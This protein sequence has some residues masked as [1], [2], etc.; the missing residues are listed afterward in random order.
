MPSQLQVTSQG[1][2]KIDN[3][4]AATV[5]DHVP[6]LNIAPFGTC[7]VLTAAASG[8]PMPCVPAPVGPWVPGS[9][10]RVTIGKHPALL[11]TDRLHCSIPGVITI[12]DPGQQD[13]EDR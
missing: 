1:D 4:L 7:K 10:S 8:T 13:T 6:V 11:S 5:Q 9:T 3:Q 12:V 2:M